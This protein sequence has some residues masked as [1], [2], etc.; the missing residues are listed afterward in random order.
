MM[1]VKKWIVFA[2]V[3]IQMAWSAHSTAVV[4]V[5]SPAMILTDAQRG[6][7]DAARAEKTP[8]PRSFADNAEWNAIRHALLEGERA[9]AF[10]RFLKALEPLLKGGEVGHIGPIERR[11]GYEARAIGE[12]ATKQSME[13]ATRNAQGLAF[14][15]LVTTR[16]DYVEAAKRHL[17]ALAALD[18]NGPTGVNQ[19]DLSARN[20]AW[21]L[22]LGLDWLYPHWTGAERGRLLAAIAPRLEDF[23]QRWV[24]GP[25]SLEK[26]P[27]DSHGNEILGALAE[28]SVLLAG[29]TPLADRW[30]AEFVPL[31][32]RLFTPFGGDDGGYANGTS[33]ATWDVGEYS[34]RHWDTL[35]RT[36]GLDMTLKPWARNF[37][38]FLTYFLP[39]GTP[40]GTFGD[41]A[42][43]N[44]SQAW[45][46]TAKAYAARVPLP[47][48]RWYARQWFQEDKQ[49]L[50]LLLA[51]V[52]SG[53]TEIS[54][55]EGTANAAYF[56]SIGWVA[57][58]SDLRDR[59]RTSL[60]FKSSPYGA[61]SHGHY[62]QNSFTLSDQGKPLLIDSGYY[63]FFGSKHHFG[64]A[65][66]TKA[67]NAVTLDGGNGQENEQRLGWDS[68]A[69][70]RISQFSSDGQVDMVVGDA[71]TSYQGRALAR[72]AIIFNRAEG[73]IAVMDRLSSPKQRTWEWN[74]HAVNR[75][76]PVD[77]QSI[78]VL[79]G[80]VRACISFKG[81]AQTSFT[82]HDQFGSEPQRDAR[83]SAP[84]ASSRRWC[85]CRS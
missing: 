26:Q 54:P 37:G 43:Q 56:P 46:L 75:F 49:S 36:L 82:Q 29:E 24:H 31:Y 1:Y 52:D 84:P 33:Y 44:L 59:G 22:A 40:I 58:H 25:R 74:I 45:A 57:M 51:P 20:V 16:Q 79:N 17:L 11:A 78:E 28:I 13:R 23:A 69:T 27:I 21:T 48:H 35:R 19:E 73:W 14:A 80:D 62:D 3:L 53:N 60:Y 30:L 68:A 7:V 18:V 64:W 9:Q 55:P 81:S 34:L 10:Q 42:E 47:F 83:A 8:R 15:A 5:K 38:R 63:D 41:A 2:L 71:S 85:P 6:E 66:R 50:D 67:H 72:R 4:P 12:V 70:G 65:I 77:A 76:L 61:A 32:A 39:P